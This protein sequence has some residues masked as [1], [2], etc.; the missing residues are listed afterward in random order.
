MQR[1]VVVRVDRLM[2]HP[3][4]LKY[5]TVSRSYK[6][7]DEKQTYHVGDEVLVAETRPLS[8]GKRWEVV[9]LIQRPA[10]E[11]IVAA[12]SE[13]TGNAGTNKN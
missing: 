11:A 7:H 6:A 4:Y 5:Y 13:E 2:R 8:R 12:P 3:K 10:E 1:T 9:E